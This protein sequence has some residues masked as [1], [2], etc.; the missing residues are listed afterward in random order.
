MTNGSKKKTREIRKYFETDENRNTTYQTQLI[1][2]I[3]KAD[4]KRKL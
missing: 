3:A 2:Y 4:L 1:G